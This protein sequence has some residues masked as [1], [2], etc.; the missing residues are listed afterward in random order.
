MS[1]LYIFH[2]TVSVFNLNTVTG[3]LCLEVEILKKNLNKLIDLKNINELF[4]VILN[5][6]NYKLII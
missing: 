5:Q 6:E 3:M 1:V 2:P 4:E